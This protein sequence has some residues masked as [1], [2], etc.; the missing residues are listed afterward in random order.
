MKNPTIG[1]RGKASAGFENKRVGKVVWRKARTLKV[2][3]E[4]ERFERRW[5]V[6][7]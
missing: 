4:F 5:A 1:K 2:A 6:S 3:K 7:K